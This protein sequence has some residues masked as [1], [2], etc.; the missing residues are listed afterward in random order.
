MVQFI[1]QHHVSGRVFWQLWKQFL[2]VDHVDEMRVRTLCEILD[3]NAV[4][5]PHLLHYELRLVDLDDQCCCTSRIS[6]R[7][8]EFSKGVFDRLGDVYGL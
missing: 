8:S 3:A 1:R 5:Q 6:T 2:L 4:K 7:K